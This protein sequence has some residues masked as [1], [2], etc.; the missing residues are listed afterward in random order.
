LCFAG[1]QRTL[2]A[3][4]AFGATAM[5]SA[6]YRCYVAAC[7]ELVITPLTTEQLGALIAALLER[8]AA[9]LH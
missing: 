5:F 7:A 9:H 3:F 2:R 8:S 4:L 1:T 6:F